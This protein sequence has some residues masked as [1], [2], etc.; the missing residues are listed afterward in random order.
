MTLHYRGEYMAL[1]FQQVR[2][3][4][5]QMGENALVRAQYL[6]EKRRKA[7]QILDAYAAELVSL[8]T[9]VDTAISA[10][11]NLRCAVPTS[12]KLDHR[13]SCPTI[14]D[15]VTVL[16]AD[17][18]QINPDRHASVDF[19]LVNVGGIQMRCDAPDAP[20]TTVQ[21][22]LLYDNQMYTSSGHITERMVALMRDLR[23]RELLAYLTKKIDPPVITLTDGP[24][25]LWVGRHGAAQA[26]EYEKK[27]KRY[28]D[29]LRQLHSAGASTAGYI[30]K[31]RGDL[32]VRLLEIATLPQNEI[33]KAG[34]EYR[35]YLG[36]TD[37]NI[38]SALLAPGERSAI[39]GIQSRNASKYTAELALHFFYLN[40]S[41]NE[42]HPYPVRVEIPAWVVDNSQMLNDLHAVLIDQT[43]MLGSRPFPYLLHRSHEVAVVTHDEKR[44]VENMIA[45]ELRHRGVEVGQVSQKQAVKNASQQTGRYQR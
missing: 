8:Q 20:T 10:N 33:D 14:P 12:E 43:Q 28:L 30:D 35:P 29:A 36:V 9:K 1:D 2:Q 18:S 24:L 45:L 38:F 21:S 42:K 34:R 15:A 41:Q 23:E 44:Q 7:R 13:A 25:E 39:F 17:G 40:V 32:L 3:Q 11:P 27:F 31:P 37:A 22:Q 6:R 5:M 16:A 19:C 26:R 4:V